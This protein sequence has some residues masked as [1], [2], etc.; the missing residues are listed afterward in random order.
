ME[1][2]VIIRDWLEHEENEV[3]LDIAFLMLMQL[4]DEFDIALESN[5]NPARLSNWL[6]PNGESKYRTLGK[7]ISFIAI[8]EHTFANRFD[9][10]GWDLPRQVFES[11]I[12]NTSQ[13]S[14]ES[15]VEKTKQF[16]ADLPRKQELW[17]GVGKRWQDVKPR[18]SPD[19]LQEWVRGF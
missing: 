15:T 7:A 10:N 17:A 18:L 1:P 14:S 19:A 3:K 9:K 4:D 16:L 6:T 5:E 2:T 12:E 13:E 8:F 11:V